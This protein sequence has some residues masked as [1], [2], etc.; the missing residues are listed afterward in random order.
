MLLY[1]AHVYD[2]IIVVEPERYNIN[3]PISI[4][5]SLKKLD[6]HTV[7]DILAFLFFNIFDKYFINEVIKECDPCT[8]Y[9]QTRVTVYSQASSSGML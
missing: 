5:M 7:P 4:F 8:F 3:R 6:A 1:R 2:I 9:S